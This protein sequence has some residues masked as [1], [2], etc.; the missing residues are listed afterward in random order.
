MKKI[1]FLISFL[2]LHLTLSAQ[3]SQAN[4]I[5]TPV[6]SPFSISSSPNGLIE[7]TITEV[8]GKVSTAVTIANIG[9]RSVTYPVILSYNGTKVFNQAQYMNKFM[10]QSTVGVGWIMG[11]PKIVVDHKGTATRED[12]TFY[13]ADGTNN[14]KLV[15]T[16]KVELEFPNTGDSYYEFE[17][18][19]F[20]AYKIRYK[21]N[22]R[23]YNFGNY[24]ITIHDYWEIVNDKGITYT[25]GNSDNKRENIIAW[26]N[27]IGDSNNT[28]GA[29]KLTTAW[30]LSKIQ[31][32]WTNRLDFTYVKV[33]QGIASTGPKHTEAS[34]LKEIS[35]SAGGKVVFNYNNKTI[36][37]YYEPH[38]EISE[39]DAYQEQYEK[40]YLS[41]IETYNRINQLVYTYNLG[42]SVI[43]KS[44]S[45]D[46]NRFLTSITQK[47]NAENSLPPQEFEYITT[48]VFE[49]ALEKITYSTR[50]STTYN[51]VEKT[52]FYTGNPETIIDGTISDGY[53]RVGDVAGSDFVLSFQ[54]FGTNN[55]NG[56]TIDY[57]TRILSRYW[58]GEKWRMSEFLIPEPI[59]FNGAARADNIRFVKGNDF[60]AFLVFN[61]STDKGSL[62][63]FHREKNG[64]N[65]KKN[66]YR[67]ITIESGS[68][69]FSN[70]DPVLIAGEDFV[71]IGT[72][73]PGRLLTY[74]WNGDGWNPK[75]I[76]Q[77]TGQF[78]Y[79]AANNFIIALDEKDGNGADVI[80]GVT[81]HPDNYYIHY[82]DAEKNWQ[83]KS[84]SAP[85]DNNFTFIAGTDMPSY[86]YPSNNMVGFMADN[87]KEF[88]LRWDINYDLIDVDDV[89]V[90]QYPDDY[91]MLPIGQNNFTIFKRNDVGGFEPNTS[92][93]LKSAYFNGT[94]WFVQSHSNNFAQGSGLNTSL[95][96]RYLSNVNSHWLYRYNPN[97]HSVE[98]VQLASNN[99]D[100]VDMN[101]FAVNP[102]LALAGQYAYYFDNSGSINSLGQVFGG[103]TANWVLNNSNQIA[104]QYIGSSDHTSANYRQLYFI[105]VDKKNGTLK[106]ELIANGNINGP[107][108][109]H[110]SNQKVLQMG[111]Y[112]PF[113][114]ENILI[115]GKIGQKRIVNDE[116][117]T[118]VKNIVASSIEIND[119][120]GEVRKISYTYHDAYTL[121]D[122]KSTF[123]GEVEVQNKGYGSGNNGKIIKY[124]NNG[125]NDIQ[126]AG[127][128]IKIIV[129]DKNNI[130]KS[131]TE[132][133]WIKHQIPF[134]NSLNV[135][136]DRGYDLR[137]KKR[138]ETVTI[139]GNDL[140]KEINYVYNEKGYPISVSTTN[141]LGQTESSLTKYAYTQY[142]TI[143]NRNM[144]V[145][146]FEIKTSVGSTI[147]STQRFLWTNNGKNYVQ[148]NESGKDQNHLRL[149][150]E[151]SK[152]DSNGNI[153]ESTNGL[154]IYKTKLYSYNNLNPVATITNSKYDDVLDEL[155]V[156]YSEL[157]NL[158]NSNLESELIKLYN[159]MPNAMI[160]ISI[161]D[162]QGRVVK[163][164]DERQEA[165]NFVFDSFGRLKY[166][167]D[168]ND[169]VIE[170][171]EYN[172]GS[173]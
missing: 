19:V 104:I 121:P 151:T 50:G 161:Y 65:W 28:T 165:I 105:S 162:N 22:N 153:L 118:A 33:E 157:Q 127:L 139:N 102:Q 78:Y 49:G 92:S 82:L 169:K 171:K 26:G 24:T 40:K 130:T 110:S 168:S 103:L 25:Y 48:G 122:D 137:M 152:V 83:T 86:L 31:D 123:Y 54:K 81:T 98:S 141:S 9:S 99:P 16:K 23:D 57:Q 112:Y 85:I 64:I 159:R 59:S 89:F 62:Y 38:T 47:D 7:N 1:T 167:T 109:T 114:S 61:R 166:T 117:Q 17:A 12:D 58:V 148:K 35:S 76:S 13:L 115:I 93:H 145:F 144:L 91:P 5:S 80:T 136:V 133:Q 87:N 84:W 6:Q 95:T 67:N 71:A 68:I 77:G 46:K 138:T 170:K 124:F 88:I 10:P 42:Y 147:V 66:Q 129:E 55:H 160:N 75:S 56:Q 100:N 172:Y 135:T 69:N 74:T 60:Y 11:V 154:G 53:Y 120:K 126:L 3:N 113:M 116:I 20:A 128:P 150:K 4:D 134:F 142:S 156:T 173:N 29:S 94:S 155:D 143:A 106:K 41:T 27:W 90:Q 30:N 63:L 18:E 96:R 149:I 8:T 140:V 51:Y 36:L 163:T 164:L 101:A 39:P 43:N 14:T 34:Y 111:G 32:Q 21:I 2:I 73:R 97:I 132:M 125:E 107:S 72:N 37:E 119:G 79:G 15:C 131:E 45:A 44:S 146:P 70:E 108:L 158:T 52:S